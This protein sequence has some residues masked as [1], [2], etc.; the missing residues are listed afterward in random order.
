MKSIMNIFLIE[1]GVIGFIGTIVGGISGVILSLNLE[2]ILSFIEK[3][4]GFKILSPEVY[5][6][7][8]IPVQV[9]YIDVISIMSS[10]IVIT[11]LATIYPAWQASRLDPA[12]ALRYE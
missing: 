4:F 7:D 1:G 6:L 2:K 11:L 12:E 5:Y 3:S 8:R 10:A 9:N